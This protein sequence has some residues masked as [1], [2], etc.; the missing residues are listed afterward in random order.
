MSEW[1]SN[2]TGCSDTR[3][4]L[5]SSNIGHQVSYPYS[6]A[7]SNAKLMLY[8]RILTRIFSDGREEDKRFVIEY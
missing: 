1:Y 8:I 6:T 5:G 3:I 4:T 7:R 2:A